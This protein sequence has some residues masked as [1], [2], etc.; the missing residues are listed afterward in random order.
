MREPCP[1][2]YLLRTTRPREFPLD[3]RM[4]R[5]A[6][7]P[8]RPGTYSPVMMRRLA[9]VFVLGAISGAVRAQTC[10]D[11]RSFDFRNAS[12]PIAAQGDG[13]SSGP[14]LFRLQNGRG[15]SSDDP[16]SSQSHDWQLNLVADRL[17][18][19]DPSTWIRLI[20]VDRNHL[21][22]TGDWRYV[23]AFHC[24]HGS[25]VSLLQYGS[26][27]V[28]L[29]HLSEQ[30]LIL[31]QAIWKKGDPH[32]CPS[33]KATAVTGSPYAVSSPSSVAVVPQS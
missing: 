13:S 23:M 4:F 9:L 7:D 5:I 27:G 30:T 20:V 16:G 8:V 3:A 19:P 10:R 32:C 21:T 15:F 18:H 12:I 33:G 14:D 17:E 6:G 28:E 2:R 25:L 29:K 22:G 26:E 31:D 11:I 24:Q 1:R